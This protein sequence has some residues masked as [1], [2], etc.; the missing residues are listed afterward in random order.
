M[1]YF[2]IFT[3]S[4][5]WAYTRRIRSFWCICACSSDAENRAFSCFS[6]LLLHIRGTAEIALLRILSVVLWEVRMHHFFWFSRVLRIGR[7]LPEF[8]C[9]GVSVRAHRE[10]KMVHFPVFRSF[11][12]TDEKLQNS[13]IF[14]HSAWFVGAQNA[15]FS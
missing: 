2:S 13:H 8:A 6:Q 14:V 15:A 12:S 11:R 7:K 5:H 3:G 1:Q 9:S 10:L 4:Q